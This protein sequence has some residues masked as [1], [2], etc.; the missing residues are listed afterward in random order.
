MVPFVGKVGMPFPQLAATPACVYQRGRD[1]LGRAEIGPG[2]ARG[3][4][5]CRG[6]G[7]GQPMWMEVEHPLRLPLP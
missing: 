3:A 6:V 1:Q 5:H 7:G 2:A 4:Q